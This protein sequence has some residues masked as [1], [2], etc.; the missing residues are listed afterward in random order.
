M[1][2]ISM[3]YG[4]IICMYP[5]DD[6]QHHKPHIHV[7]YAGEK[8]VFSIEDGKMIKGKIPPKQVK[9]VEAWMEIHKKE[10]IA[11]WELATIEKEVYKIEP[12]K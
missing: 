1:P 7:R 3:F 2:S 11:N 8:A 12:L 4:P 5:S 6:K 9:L 10:L